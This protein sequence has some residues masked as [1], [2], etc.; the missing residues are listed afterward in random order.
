MAEQPG[1]ELAPGC[2][3]L[4]GGCLV[5][6]QQSVQGLEHR[7][8]QQAAEDHQRSQAHTE[9]LLHRDHTIHTS[10]KNAA[11]PGGDMPEKPGAEPFFSADRLV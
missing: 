11:P 9:L 7:V 8:L 3:G 4:G 1:A 5:G 6:G 2:R 10:L